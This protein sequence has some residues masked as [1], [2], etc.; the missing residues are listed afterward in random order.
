MRWLMPPDATVLRADD[1]VQYESRDR[2][3]A[4]KY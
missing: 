3:T 1:I 4:R 2:K